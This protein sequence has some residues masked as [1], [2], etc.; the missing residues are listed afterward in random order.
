M[1]LKARI[2]EL[3]PLEEETE[4][5]IRFDH[6]DTKECKRTELALSRMG[7]R[8]RIQT[9]LALRDAIYRNKAEASALLGDEAVMRCDNGILF[10]LTGLGNQL[11]CWYGKPGKV[12]RCHADS[13]GKGLLYTI[14]GD[15]RIVRLYAD[16]LT[17]G[18]TAYQDPLEG[19]TV[20][21]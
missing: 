18:Y 14:E 16:S 3:V 6:F 17:A 10:T 8:E 13:A 11:R 2:E 5:E 1:S 20:Y 15:P 12:D 21:L 7:H 9:L 4:V 19:G